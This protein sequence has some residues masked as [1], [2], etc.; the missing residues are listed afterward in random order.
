[1]VATGMKKGIALII[2]ANLIN[3]V[4][5]L[6]NGFVLP[7]FLSVESYAMI[8]TFTLYSTFAGIF[9]LGY[10]DGM[11]LKY[12]GRDMMAVSSKEY[13]TDLLNVTIMQLILSLVLLF[14]GYL[15]DDFVLSAFAVSLLLINLISCFQMFFQATGEFKLYSS[16][17]NYGT[18]LSLVIS[19]V[20]VFLIKTDDAKLYITALLFSNLV[21]VIYIGLLLNVKIHFLRKQNISMAAVKENISTG[22]VLMIGNFSNSLFT[23]IDR[24]LVKILMTTFSFATY[25]FAISIDAL[26][27]VFIHPLFV[28]LYNAF[29]KDHSAD[30]VLNIKRLVLMWGFIIILLAFPAKWFVENYM[31][32]YNAAIPLIFI[33]FCSQVFYAVIKGVY[34]NYFKALKMQ[35]QYFRQIMIMLIV[36]VIFSLLLYITFKTMMSLAVAGLLTAIIWLLANEIRFKELRFNKNDWIYFTTLVVIYIVSGLYLP[37][38]LGFFVYLLSLIALSSIFMRQQANMLLEMVKPKILSVLHK[39][40]DK[41]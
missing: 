40:H 34:V 28:T 15:N 27:N 25:S 5:G 7:K 18:I 24:W 35:K 13:G 36:G 23:S 37:S 29:C 21:V 3:L 17:L 39:Y 1:V 41:K 32:K 2:L 10:L 38:I 31:D 12:G 26:I 14:V 6:V 19:L 8:K 11:Y 9:H 30:R 20:L 16:A 22:I 4:I 33:L